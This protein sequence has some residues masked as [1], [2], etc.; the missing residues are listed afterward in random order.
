MD[1]ARIY[2]AG[3][4]YL[5][6]EAN[7]ETFRLLRNK[8]HNRMFIPRT[9][10]WDRMLKEHALPSLTRTVLQIDMKT[11]E[12]TRLASFLQLPAGYALRPFDR[13]VYEMHPF[14]HGVNYP[15]YEDFAQR[16]AGTVAVYDGEIVASA[17]SFLS[18]ENALELDVS[19]L[20]AHRKRGLGLACCAGML[21]DCK[22]RGLEVHWDAQNAVSRKMAEKLGYA[23]AYEYAAYGFIMPEAL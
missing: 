7:D 5:D 9:A 10:S 1:G 20:P 21:L 18:Y 3:F 19:T 14:Y 13:A 12:E 22:A 15:A 23:F 16:G 8:W 2:E 11:L 17:S 4:I 6:G